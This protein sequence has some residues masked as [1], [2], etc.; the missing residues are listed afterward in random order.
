MSGS[1]FRK[2][3]TAPS[4]QHPHSPQHPAGTVWPQ[5]QILHQRPESQRPLGKPRAGGCKG[6]WTMQAV[7]GRGPS[8]PGSSQ[9][10][11]PRG[12]TRWAAVPTKSPPSTTRI[13]LSGRVSSTSCSTRTGFR[14][15]AT[16]INPF[17][18]PWSSARQQGQQQSLPGNHNNTPGPV[19]ALPSPHRKACSFCRSACRSSSVQSEAHVWPLR[20]STS[21]NT[22]EATSPREGRGYSCREVASCPSSIRGPVTAGIQWQQSRKR[23][24]GRPRMFLGQNRENT[25]QNLPEP[26]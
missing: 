26:G 21:F 20:P 13:E 9:H 14:C 6:A 16:G 17:S 4:L 5:V 24:G 10:R 12:C 11:G 15:W 2:Q 25:P 22:K 8:L 19:S 23:Q 18:L 7:P 3:C 1:L